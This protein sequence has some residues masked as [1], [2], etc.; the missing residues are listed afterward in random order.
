MLGRPDSLAASVVVGAA[1]LLRVWRVAFIYLSS[2]SEVYIHGD[3]RVV[4]QLS[5][6]DGAESPVDTAV[7]EGIENDLAR[8]FD[9]HIRHIYPADGA[10]PLTGALVTAEIKGMIARGVYYRLWMRRP[11]RCPQ[12]ILTLYKELMERF[13]EFGKAY[14]K[15]RP[16]DRSPEI[17]PMRSPTGRSKNVFEQGGLYDGLGDILGSRDMP[18]DEEARS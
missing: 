15:E 7:V 14:S 5:R 9:N 16:M 12:N 13:E 17:E 1:V 11:D 8:S 6:D 4:A 10:L 3:R 18:G 2:I